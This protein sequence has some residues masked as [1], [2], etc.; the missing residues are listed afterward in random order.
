MP[1]MPSETNCSRIWIC[2]AGSSS[3][4]EP[5]H[6]VSTPASFAP[7]RAPVSTVFQYT[8]VVLL[9]ITAID[10]MGLRVYRGKGFK[11]QDCLYSC[12]QSIVYLFDLDLAARQIRQPK[13]SSPFPPPRAKPMK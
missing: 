3:L 1:P 5:F 2:C 12:S 7:S 10:F 9:G 8:C 11:L 4:R 6:T 13:Q